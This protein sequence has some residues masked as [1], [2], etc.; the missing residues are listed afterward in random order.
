MIQET[1]NDLSRDKAVRIVHALYKT[2]HMAKAGEEY[3][4]MSDANLNQSDRKIVQQI[5]NK[6]RSG[7]EEGA[8]IDKALKDLNA[9]SDQ[10]LKPSGDDE[11]RGREL[12]EALT[13]SLPGE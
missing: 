8:R 6:I 10:L 12:L 4:F 9:V 1:L 2:L 3:D 11:K 7:G 5:L 13:G